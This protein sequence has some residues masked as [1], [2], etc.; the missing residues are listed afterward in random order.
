M[1]ALSRA[2]TVDVLKLC[3]SNTTRNACRRERNII[4]QDDYS[5][6]KIAVVLISLPAPST[7]IDYVDRFVVPVLL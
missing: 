3:Y 1:H 2:I 4:V 5:I 6:G 7:L